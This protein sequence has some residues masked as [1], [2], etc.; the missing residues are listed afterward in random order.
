MLTVLK[1]HGLDE[2]F[3]NF[4]SVNE[5]PVTNLRVIVFTL[6]HED[7]IAD[8]EIVLKLDK[9]IAAAHVNLGLIYMTKLENYTK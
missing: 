3:R 4:Y 2:K 5:I 7:A 1:P 9:S 8:F 6:R